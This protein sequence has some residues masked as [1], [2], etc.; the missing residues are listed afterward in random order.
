[1]AIGVVAT[2]MPYYHAIWNSLGNSLIFSKS[3]KELRCQILSRD[4]QSGLYCMY[5]KCVIVFCSDL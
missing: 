1:M 2:K 3:V 4:G 5:F